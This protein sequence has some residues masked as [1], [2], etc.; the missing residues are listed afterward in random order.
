MTPTIAEVALPVPLHKLFDYRLQG[1]RPVVGGRVIVPFGARKL[2]GVVLALKTSSDFEFAK[3]KSVLSVLDQ[4]P[5]WPKPLLELLV[6]AARYYHYPLGETLHL[7]LPALLRRGKGHTARE[8]YSWQL[9]ALGHNTAPE[10]LKRAPKQAELLALLHGG[11]LPETAAQI[12]APIIKALHEKGLAEKIIAASSAPWPTT[13]ARLQAPKTLSAEQALAVATI[14]SRDDFACYLLDGVTGSGKTEVYLNV[15]EPV[16]AKGRQALLLVPEIGL[17]PQLTARFSTRFNVPVITLHSKLNDSERLAAWQAA[18]HNEAAIIIG[19]RSAL[20]SPFQTL[21]MIIVDEE[22]DDSYKQ[23]DSLRYHARDLA[24]LRAQRENIP[25]VLGSAT[26]SLET[27]HNAANKK[28]HHLSLTQRAGN[29]KPARQAIIDIRNL[30]LQAGLSAPLL[31]QMRQHLQDGNQVML[32]LNRRGFAPVLM[33]HACGWIAKCPRCDTSYTLHQKRNALRCHRCQGQKPQPQQCPDCEESQLIHVGTGTEKLE[34]TLG[35]LFPQYRTLRI[36][37]DT[38][39]RKGAFERHLDAIHQKECQIVIGT[40]MLAKGHHFPQITLVALIDVDSALFSQDFRAPEKL[41]QLFVQVA[42]RSGRASKPGTVLLQTRHPE[43]PLLKALVH[44]NYAHFAAQA[45]AERQS[46]ELPPFSSFCL[47]RAKAHDSEQ[48]QQFLQTAR[49]LL[50]TCQPAP[51]FV[52]G[53]FSPAIARM[54]GFFHWQLILQT[55]DKKNMQQWLQ[56]ALPQLRTTPLANKV[57]WSVDVDPQQ[58]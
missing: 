24:V 2:V 10:T 31:E 36:D 53:P 39:L 50:Q 13:F 14:N 51:G 56:W 55:P 1:Q 26:P 5:L 54:A 3:L 15:L 19:T 32:F 27:L 11:P 30:R 44:K 40:Q 4:Q 20:F 49:E 18:A 48:A 17:T 41:A 28:Y 7:A 38:T 22:H 57:H 21:G 33:C 45:L 23:Q 35:V 34:E 42:G 25:I 43:H 47:L 12:S 52:L 16:L 29:A 37:R 9:T 8:S 58:M 46:T 6:W